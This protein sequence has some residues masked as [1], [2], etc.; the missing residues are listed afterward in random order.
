MSYGTPPIVTEDSCCVQLPD[1]L[2]GNMLQHPG[3]KS[4]EKR[5][6]GELWSVTTGS[7]NRYKAKMYMMASSIMN[8]IYFT[9]HNKPGELVQLIKGFFER[10]L[11]WERSVP[12]E[13]QLESHV[14]FIPSEGKEGFIRQVFAIQAL[15][16]RISYDNLLIFLFRPLITIGSVSQPLLQRT[17]ESSP[18][19][20]LASILATGVRP[21]R[22][23]DAFLQVAETQCWTSATRTSMV[24]QRFNIRNLFSYSFPALHVGIYA[25]SAGVMLAL[26]ALSYPLS[27]RGDECKRGIARIIQFSRSAQLRPHMRSQMSEVLTDLM[28]AIASEETKA[29]IASP[30]GVKST[31]EIYKKLHAHALDPTP[32]M[33]L[34]SSGGGSQAL[35]TPCITPGATPRSDSYHGNSTTSERADEQQLQAHELDTELTLATPPCQTSQMHGNGPCTCSKVHGKRIPSDPDPALQEMLTGSPYGDMGSAMDVWTAP[36]AEWLGDPL[37]GMNQVWMWNGTFSYH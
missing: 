20:C 2:E 19:A 29:L 9:R 33:C 36:H 34:A 13:L 8:Q 17:R 15:T 12:P 25:F 16:L 30:D 35:H 1:D 21:D 14:D 4:M 26:L 37:Q 28:H 31:T 32:E 7:Y 22:V 6:D 27:T 5:E 10:V 3:F 24:F 18:A 23:P 11:E